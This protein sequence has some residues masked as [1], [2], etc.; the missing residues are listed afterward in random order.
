MGNEQVGVLTRRRIQAE[1][2]KPIYEVMVREIGAEK[3]QAIIGEAITADAIR[4]GQ[5]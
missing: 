2:I 3:A 4:E 1:V 5:A